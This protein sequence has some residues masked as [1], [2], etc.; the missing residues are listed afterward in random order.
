AEPPQPV[1]PDPEKLDAALGRERAALAVAFDEE[2]AELQA[3][4]SAERSALEAALEEERAA[5]QQALQ[6][7]VKARA[8]AS[9]RTAELSDLSD[10]VIELRGQIEESV[11]VVAAKRHA[12]D[13]V[14]D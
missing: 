2:R 7:L 12:V 14:S 11:A 1:V 10:Q 5:R 9:A 3:A 4:L 6:E 8:D 13:H